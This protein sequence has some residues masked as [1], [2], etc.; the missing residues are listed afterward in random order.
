MDLWQVYAILFYS[1]PRRKH[2][3]FFNK[4]SESEY[5]IKAAYYLQ[6]Y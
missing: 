2:N 3:V 1:I 5:F 6:F 4:E